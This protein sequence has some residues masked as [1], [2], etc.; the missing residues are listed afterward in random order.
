MCADVRNGSLASGTPVQTY[1]CNAEPNQQFEFSGGRIYTMGGQRCL[2]VIL[3][4]MKGGQINNLQVVSNICDPNSI[5]QSAWSATDGGIVWN[6]LGD[7][8]NNS[9]TLCLDAGNMAN[10]TQ[11]HLTNTGCEPAPSTLWQIK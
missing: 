7:A 11:L 10:G 9:P 8:L 1:D 6:W 4:L 3:K 2:D 5:T